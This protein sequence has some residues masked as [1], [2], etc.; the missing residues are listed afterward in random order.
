MRSRLSSVVTVLFVGSLLP[1]VAFAGG[2]AA[3]GKAL[4]AKKCLNCHGATGKG[5]GPALAALKVKPKDLSDKAYMAGLKDQ[6]LADIVSKG[7]KALGKS[8]IMPAMNGKLS[9]GEIRDIVAFLRTLA[10]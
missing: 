5:D 9:D 2:D 8:P 10:R 6:Y 3:N 4:Y 7:G 1:A